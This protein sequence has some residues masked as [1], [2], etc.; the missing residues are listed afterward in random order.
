MAFGTA[1]SDSRTGKE[2]LS[3]WGWWRCRL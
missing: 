1:E 3:A 2:F